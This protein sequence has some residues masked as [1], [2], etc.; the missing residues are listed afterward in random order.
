VRIYTPAGAS[1]H[2]VLVYFHGGGWVLCNL[3]THD[4][5]CRA[6][7]NAAQCI[8]VSVDYRLAPE[9]KFPAALDDCYA[10]TYWVAKNAA[11]LGGD[12]SRIAIGGDS[13]GGNLTATVALKARDEGSPKL[14]HQLLVYPV[15]D[16]R[17]DSGS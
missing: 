8:V 7:A 10:A 4:G 12:P 13:A 9:H 3:D 17:C 1:P 6:L 15:T 14:V 2:P 5:T 16:A 11:N